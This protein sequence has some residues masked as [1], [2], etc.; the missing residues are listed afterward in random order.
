M[1]KAH[2]SSGVIADTFGWS[3]GVQVKGL[4]A[5]AWIAAMSGSAAIIIL[6]SRYLIGTT[7]Q[8]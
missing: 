8:E 2:G 3:W 6:E 1:G 7:R 5:S 4:P